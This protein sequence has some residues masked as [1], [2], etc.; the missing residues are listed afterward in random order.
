MKAQRA[1]RMTRREIRMKFSSRVVA[2]RVTFRTGRAASRVVPFDGPLHPA[3][4]G[5]SGFRTLFGFGQSAFAA[6]LAPSMAL[7]LRAGSAVR[8]RSRRAQ[9]PLPQSLRSHI[10]AVYFAL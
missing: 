9:S 3:A 6:L 5:A 4:G 2:A 7:A 1:K 10:S 8:A